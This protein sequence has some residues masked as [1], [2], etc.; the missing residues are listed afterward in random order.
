MSFAPAKKEKMKMRLCLIG[1][2]GTGKTYTAQALA[3]SFGKKIAVIDSERSA[4][5]YADKFKF[6]VCELENHSPET[7]I[8]EIKAAEA[9]GYDVLIIDSLSHA[10]MGKDGALEQVDKAAKRSQSSNSFAA[11]RDVTPM[12]NKLVDAIVLSKLHIICTLRAKTEY[13]IEK[14][15]R[16]RNVPR[17]VGMAPIQRD[18]VEF[19]FTI[20]GDMNQN[21]ELV[22]GKTRCSL[23]DGMIVSKPGKEFGDLLFNWLNDGVAPSEKKAD[24]PKKQVSTSPTTGTAGGAVGSK[25]TQTSP[26]KDVV[27][28]EKKQSG[29]ASSAE[30][31]PPNPAPDAAIAT[32]PEWKLTKELVEKLANAGVKNGWK[33]GEISNFLVQQYDYPVGFGEMQYDEAMKLISSEKNQSGEVN[34]DVNGVL[35]IKEKR[36]PRKP[37]AAVATA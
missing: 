33:K 36:F 12:H 10:W 11:W 28:E 17:K 8:R 22:V 2:T 26:A 7:Y 27:T 34:F 16:G 19:E 29:N 21:H 31:N 20:V 6:D 23:V 32:V 9:A 24:E 3:E 37:A 35:L 25:D 5:I 1:P 18:G 13:V 15:D 14:D 30:S 4:S